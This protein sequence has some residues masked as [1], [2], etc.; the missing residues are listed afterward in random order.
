MKIKDSGFSLVSVLMATAL[1]GGLAVM[2]MQMMKN[3]NQGQGYVEAAAEEVAL[4][5]EIDMILGNP[6]F[7]RVSLAGPGPAGSPTSP[8]TFFKRDITDLENDPG[9]EVELWLADTTGEERTNKKFD[10]L[11]PAK[12]KYGKLK[13]KEIKLYMTNGDDQNYPDASY[14]DDMGELLVKYEKPIGSNK[15]REMVA[16]FPLTVGM[17]TTSGETTIVSCSKSA[18]GNSASLTGYSSNCRI[19][20]SHRDNTDPWRHS[21]YLDMS[22]PGFVG[23]RQD[24]RMNSDDRLRVRMSNC[25]FT[26][27]DNYLKNCRFGLGRRDTM[28]SSTPNPTPDT[29]S[30]G[31]LNIGVTYHVP[32]G[33]VEYDDHFY[34]RLRCPAGPN[35]ELHDYMKKNCMVCM[36]QS[37][38]HRPSPDTSACSQIQDSTGTKWDRFGIDGETD[39]DDL[40]FFGFFCGY[41]APIV[42]G[43]KVN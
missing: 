18:G 13:L 6:K 25:G 24:G 32:I 7:C 27:I 12:N 43:I 34:F 20:L 8:E 26:E 29:S 31:L 41:Y 17:S 1:M 28:H 9:K 5:N 36:G 35:P 16:K 38:L 4:R 10:A 30:E 22:K 15:T 33:T 23:I 39:G 40:F 21:P 3:M 19:R 42:Q 14:H 37:D 2:F 11:D